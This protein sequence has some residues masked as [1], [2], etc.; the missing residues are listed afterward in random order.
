M[1]ENESSTETRVHSWLK[2]VK[3]ALVSCWIG[4][5]ILCYKLYT[6]IPNVSPDGGLVETWMLGLGCLYLEVT[7]IIL[8]PVDFNIAMIPVLSWAIVFLFMWIFAGAELCAVGS[9]HHGLVYVILSTVPVGLLLLCFVIG[10]MVSVL[11]AVL[12]KEQ[13]QEHN[14]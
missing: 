8:L 10:T 13:E 3:V 9:V 4:W 5:T 11:K 6:N 7:I 12:I 2:Y 14:A 1:D